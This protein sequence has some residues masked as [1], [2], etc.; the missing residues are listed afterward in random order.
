MIQKGNKMNKNSKVIHVSFMHVREDQLKHQSLEEIA[1]EYGTALPLLGK[2]RA[3]CK[4]FTMCSLTL[5][6]K[7]ETEINGFSFCSGLDPFNKAKG[8]LIAEGRARKVLK[9]MQAPAKRKK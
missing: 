2:D 6:N 4:G 5:D 7:K 8:R 3:E 9:K 1:L